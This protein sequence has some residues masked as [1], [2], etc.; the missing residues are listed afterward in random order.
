[1]QLHEVPCTFIDSNTDTGCV[2]IVSLHDH[3]AYGHI[4]VC[5]TALGVDA[6]ALGE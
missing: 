3:A 4:S 2:G 1:V 5:C 6:G